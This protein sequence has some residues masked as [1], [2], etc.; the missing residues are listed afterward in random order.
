M[1]TLILRGVFLS[2]RADVDYFFQGNAA[3]FALDPL[4]MRVP[5]TYLD[6][7]AAWEH[8]VTEVPPE[9][10][11]DVIRG[12][13]KMFA[14]QPQNE[15]ERER[16]LKAASDCV[17][18]G[19]SASRLK[20]DES[21]QSQPNQKY[22]LMAG[23]ILIHYMVHG[24]LLRVLERAA[25]GEVGGDARDAEW[26]ATGSI[27]AKIYGKTGAF[28]VRDPSGA[29]RLRRPAA[30]RVA[31][32][33][34]VFASAGDCAARRQQHAATEDGRYSQGEA[35]TAQSKLTCH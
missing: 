22:A 24:H 7:P 17:A 35:Q 21:S 9:D 2:R 3:D 5:G 34:Y 28:G 19:S 32:R 14:V 23:R 12:L 27:R 1:Q 6:F 10:R 31:N 4:G 26:W 30:D 16:V 8:F 18:W 25:I 33:R 15:A 29:L 20:R 11:G 13:A